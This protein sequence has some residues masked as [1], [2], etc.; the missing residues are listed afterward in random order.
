VTNLTPSELLEFPAASALHTLIEDQTT[1]FPH[2]PALLADDRQLS[3]AELSAR[4]NR[5]AH[6]LIGRGVAPGVNVAIALDRSPDLVVSLLGV[7][8][9]GGVC[10]PLDPQHP[11][12]RLAS[13]LGRADIALLLTRA[14][15]ADRLSPYTAQVIPLDWSAEGLSRLPES[16]PAVPVTADDPAAIF[17]TSGSTGAPKPVLMTHRVCWCGVPWNQANV[18]SLGPSDRVLMTSAVSFSSIVGELAHPLLTGAAVVPARP[19]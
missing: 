13:L 3:Y 10:V 8:K 1:R 12:E 18:V 2:L 6:L 7:W 9:A 17:F 15:F 5:L 11:P 14:E 4:A 16:N 19:Q